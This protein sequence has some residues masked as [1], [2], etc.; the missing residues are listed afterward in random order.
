MKNDIYLPGIWV[1]REEQPILEQIRNDH[2]LIVRLKITP[3]ELQA[4]SKCAFMGSPTSMEDMLF[5]LRQIRESNRPL[6]Q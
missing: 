6:V 1:P 2:E 3:Q 4:L 5:I